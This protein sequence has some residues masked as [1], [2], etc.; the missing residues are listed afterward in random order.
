MELGAVKLHVGWRRSSP[1][2]EGWRYK[3]RGRGCVRRVRHKD[4]EREREKGGGWQEYEVCE[5]RLVNT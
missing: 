4:R 3:C 5:I 1:M 2:A